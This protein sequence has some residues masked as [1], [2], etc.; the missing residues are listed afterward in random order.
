MRAL[1]LLFLSLSLL[2]LRLLLHFF[3]LSLLTPPFL[4]SPA[5]GVDGGYVDHCMPQSSRRE[6]SGWSKHHRKV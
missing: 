4:S 3:S 1:S 5:S 6:G 2:S